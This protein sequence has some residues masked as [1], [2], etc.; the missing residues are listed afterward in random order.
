MDPVQNLDAEIQEAQRSG[1]GYP[2]RHEQYGGAGGQGDVALSRPPSVR[3]VHAELERLGQPRSRIERAFKRAFDLVGASLLV[4]VLAPLWLAISLLIK[5]DSPGPILFRQPRIGQYG[6]PFQMF[7]FRTMVKGADARKP[8]LLHMNEAAE[9][10]FKING[11]PRL[12]R[13]GRWLRRTSIDELPQLLEVISGR[14]S[15]V[16]P[17]P[18]VPEEDRLITGSDR[19]RLAMRPGMTG[20]WQVSGAS[21]IPISEMVKL[22]KEYIDQW[23]LWFD[24]KLLL[25]TASHVAHRRGW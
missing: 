2:I 8:A 24:L 25:R 5:L 11:D 21:A 16:G 22:D 1:T 10:L 6:V 13:V 18:L 23:S 14:M 3:R 4:I 12:T 20:L 9:G 19:G 7:K 17:R 15:L